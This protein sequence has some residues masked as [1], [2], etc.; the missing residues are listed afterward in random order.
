[1]Q[2]LFD[3]DPLTGAKTYFISQDDKIIFN[4]VQDVEPTLEANAALRQ[5]DNG[6][7]R[8]DMH[9]VGSI[10]AVVANQLVRDG[11]LFDGGQ[12][13]DQKKLLKFLTDRNNLKLR[14]KGGR[15]I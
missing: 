3:V 15:L 9:L 11:V 6:N 5:Q 12:M 14:T 2:R 13:C 10:P 1:M 4:E 7:R 8:G